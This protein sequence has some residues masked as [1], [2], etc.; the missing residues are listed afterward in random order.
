ME[1]YISFEESLYGDSPNFDSVE[2]F[3]VDFVL[4]E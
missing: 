2:I 3:D 4:I 1:K